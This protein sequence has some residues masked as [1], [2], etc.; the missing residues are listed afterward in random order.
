MKRIFKRKKGGG[1]YLTNSSILTL[2]L[3][4]MGILLLVFTINVS[5][6]WPGFGG[7]CSSHTAKECINDQDC[8]L[9]EEVE[10]DYCLHKICIGPFGTGCRC[11]KKVDIVTTACTRKRESGGP[12]YDCNSGSCDCTTGTCV[13]NPDDDHYGTCHVH[14]NEALHPDW[15][16]YYR[17]E[18]VP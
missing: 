13:T 9:V 1:K 5:G 18:Q 10:E 6:M 3:L 14:H 16:E 7:G 2:V 11:V 12:K 17:C 8:A 15:D 4:F